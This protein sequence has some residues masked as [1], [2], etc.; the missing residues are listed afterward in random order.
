[1]PIR[2]SKLTF[3]V[4]TGQIW[5]ATLFVL[6]NL[7]Q[8]QNP[9]ASARRRALTF[10]CIMGGTVGSL[11]GFLAALTFF[12]E[13]PAFSL[14]TTITPLVYFIFPVLMAR[15]VSEHHIQVTSLAFTFIFISTLI[16]WAGGILS[17]GAFFLVSSCML[18]TL[19]FTRRASTIYIAAAVLLL[20]SGHIYSGYAGTNFDFTFPVMD[21]QSVSAWLLSSLLLILVFAAGSAYIFV[22]EMSRATKLLN[23]ATAR[24]EAASR[25]KSDFL[26]NM[27]HEIRTPMN[28]VLGM[29]EILQRTDLSNEQRM[30]ADTIHSSG[31]ALL[32]VINDILDYSKI[33]AGALEIDPHPFSLR[34]VVED[35]ATLL[36]VSADSKGIELMVR[37]QPDLPLSLIGDAGRLRQ[38]L[39]NIVGN[40]IKF[41]HK[42]HVLIDIS[43]DCEDSSVQLSVKI[44]DTGIGIPDDKLSSIFDKFTQAES[45]TTRQF[46]GTG[47]G[48]AIT[49]SLVEAMNG[50]IVATST[51]G[52]GS[53]F[54]ITLPLPVAEDF[55]T[56]VPDDIHLDGTPI[57][58]VDDNEVNR[59]ILE[60]QLRSWKAKPI[61]VESGAEAL[62][63]LHAAAKDKQAI[64]VAV[65]DY[66]MPR[67]DGLDLAKRIR[68]DK[69][70]SHTK[71]IV[72]SSANDDE[73][74]KAFKALGVADTF[75][76]PARSLL[77]NQAIIRAVT[78]QALDEL[79][80]IAKEQ[81]PCA[82]APPTPKGSLPPTILIA[83]DNQMNRMVLENMIDYNQYSIEFAEDGR[84]AYQKAC[85]KEYD[86]ILM[87]ISMPEMDGVDATKA[88]RAY[89][90]KHGLNRTPI[91]ALTAYALP[92]DAERFLNE[93]MD[94]YIAK[95]IQKDTLDYT[96]AKWVAPNTTTIVASK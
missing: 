74:V 57:L 43:G 56:P 22:V 51:L 28:G 89:Q 10:F 94:D 13:F 1:M 60:E 55:E 87:D 8:R 90:S 6:D 36:S 41:T 29:A 83:E 66:H 59:T 45:S 25:A 50:N 11:S 65:I 20:V 48:L 26:A 17:K 95:P 63:Q 4:G 27:S 82:K 42:G 75:Q 69:L 3:C 86:L 79:K 84:A 31:N 68:S 46:G 32:T 49:N 85:E 62:E 70:L 30:F 54:T 80:H 67:M 92:A 78:G 9:L 61:T 73:T 93:G 91:I 15:G 52:A 19:I 16:Y 33:E 64:P 47:L 2:F 40:A 38:S 96:I 35:V 34:S 77:L 71:I 39:M 24:A 58:V 81:A 88:I 21:Y 5:K 18:S 76:K 72:L 7:D 44:E 14:V 12:D 53:T 37:F 23:A